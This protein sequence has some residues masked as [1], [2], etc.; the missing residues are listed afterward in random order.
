MSDKATANPDVT[1]VVLSVRHA[2]LAYADWN[3]I[4]RM[5]QSGAAH[6]LH[7]TEVCLRNICSPCVEVTM[8]IT[9]MRSQT[10]EHRCCDIGCFV[11][12]RGQVLRCIHRR[13]TR[14]HQHMPNKNKTGS[15]RVSEATCALSRASNGLLSEENCSRC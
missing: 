8:T 2:W 13:S 3:S 5:E 12:R 15:C 4:K 7:T 9:H 1:G 6:C 14:A 10:T 11:S